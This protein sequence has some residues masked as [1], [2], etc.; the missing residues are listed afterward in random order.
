MSCIAESEF[1]H[2]SQVEYHVFWQN[3]QPIRTN[4]NK[5]G[6]IYTFSDNS[7]IMIDQH[8]LSKIIVS[9]GWKE[10]GGKYNWK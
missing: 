7:K 8:P 9:I 4:G 1:L 3:H 2:N 5:E 10:N 6:I